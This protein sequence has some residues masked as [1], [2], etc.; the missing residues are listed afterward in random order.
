MT[1]SAL[2]V[3]IAPDCYGDSLTAVEAAAAMAT[4]WN[5][6]RPA[7]QYTIAPQSDGGPDRRDSR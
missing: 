4:G 3:L 7:D 1:G 2:R 6:V 5:R